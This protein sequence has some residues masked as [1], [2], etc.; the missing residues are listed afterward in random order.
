[1]FLEVK[2]MVWKRYRRHDGT[3]DLDTSEHRRRDLWREPS[4]EFES[5]MRWFRISS[6]ISFGILGHCGVLETT[7]TVAASVAAGIGRR[8]SFDGFEPIPSGDGGIIGPFAFAMVSPPLLSK[9]ICLGGEVGRRVGVLGKNPKGFQVATY[10]NRVR[11]SCVGGRGTRSRP[12]SET[13]SCGLSWFGQRSMKM[14]CSMEI[15][16]SGAVGGEKKARK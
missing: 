15:F 8:P 7:R 6:M 13:V 16:N 14:P 1:M 2:M 4:H 5:A 9:G 11:V 12:S 10:G 3:Q